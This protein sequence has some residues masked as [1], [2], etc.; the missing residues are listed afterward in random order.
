[1]LKTT[2]STLVIIDVQG[3]LARIMQNADELFRNVAMLIKGARLLNVPI[4][5]MEQLPD[6]LGRTVEEVSEHLQGL[7]PIAKDVFSCGQN[8]AFNKRLNK[9][10][11][12]NVILAGI[13]THICVYQ[14]AKD[15]LEKNYNVEVVTDATSTRLYYNKEI[16]LEKIRSAGGQITSVETIL[17]ELQGKATG[18]NFKKLI[19][20]IK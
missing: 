1:M 10:D 2:N 12:E 16:G 17:F 20:I 8:E 11:P 19:Q 13:E 9:I 18:E 15:L 7:T 5:W 3:K 6:K 4:I 14:T